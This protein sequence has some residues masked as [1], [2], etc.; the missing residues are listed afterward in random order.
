MKASEVLSV[1]S[2]AWYSIIIPKRTKGSVCVQG[3]RIY[4]NGYTYY[5]HDIYP[6]YIGYISNC[7][8]DI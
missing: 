4:I 2:S 7:F 3:S 1:G 8:Y 6:I 5:I